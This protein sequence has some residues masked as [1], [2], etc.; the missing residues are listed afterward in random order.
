MIEVPAAVTISGVLA[1]VASG[2]TAERRRRD[3]EAGEE[4]HLVVD[5]QVLRDALGIVGNGAVVLDDEFDLLAGDG[6]ALLRHEQLGAGRDLLAGRLLLTG[7]RQNEADFDA[8][9]RLRPAA[10]RERHRGAGRGQKIPAFHRVFH[11]F[12]PLI[13]DPFRAAYQHSD[14]PLSSYRFVS[15]LQ[16]RLRPAPW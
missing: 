7:H 9:F 4:V 14:A 2:A 13:N 5:D 6:V 1:S 3:A 8:V 11:G 12:L 16:L 15:F 10:R